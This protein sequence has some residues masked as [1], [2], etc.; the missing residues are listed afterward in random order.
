[1]IELSGA[2]FA[3]GPRAVLRGVDLAVPAGQ[4]VFVVGPNGAGKTTLLRLLAGLLAPTAGSVRCLGVDP[5]RQPRR[6]LARRLAYLPQEYQLSFP[7]TVD[8]VVLMGRYPHRAPGLFGLEDE[9]DLALARAAMA[10]CDVGDLAERRFDELSGGEK[11]RALLAQSFCQ[12]AEL[13]LLDEPT[14]SLDPAHALALF[15]A[16]RAEQGERGTTAV[17][18][19]HDLNLAARFADRLLVLAGGRAVADGPPGE[20]LRDPATARAFQVAL[21]VGTTPDG[22]VPFAVPR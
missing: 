7:F 22:E 3:F 18:V 9:A 2:G 21:H 8:E 13:I 4:L 20:V 14:A 6:A 10:R 19:S 12:R 5:A 16:L 1:V 15:G 17:V 11:R